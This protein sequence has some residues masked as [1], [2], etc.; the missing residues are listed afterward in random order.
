VTQ[1]RDELYQFAPLREY[2]LKQRITIRVADLAFYVLIKMI[3]A[4]TKFEVRGS[5]HVE[6]IEAAG[7]VPIICFWHNQIF[8]GT[9]FWRDK[10]IVVLTSKSFDGEYI[11]RFIQRFGFGAIRGS[12]S[13]GGAAALIEMIRSIRDGHAMAFSVDGP[14][15][16]RHEAKPGAVLLAKKTGNPL[17]PFV[18]QPRRYWQLKSWDRMQIPVPFTRSL[19]IIGEPIYVESD[20]G[21]EK[22]DAALQTLQSK[23]DE[24]TH[25]GLDWAGVRD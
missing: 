22:V 1:P 15:G 24:L 16:P 20:A 12:S 13:R 11:A 9:Y 6:A 17:V 8:L 3:G 10:G 25:V 5:E 7:K 4:T 21:D 18:V 23:L 14:R 19:A 2:S